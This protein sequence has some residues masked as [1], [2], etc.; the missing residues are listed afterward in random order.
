MSSVF[1]NEKLTFF[2]WLGCALCI[3][4]P[5][6]RALYAPIIDSWLDWINHHRPEWQVGEAV[7][8]SDH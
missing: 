1:L 5:I 7:A 8:L 4:R 3:V 2:G 6:P